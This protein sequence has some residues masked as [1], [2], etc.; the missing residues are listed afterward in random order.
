MA[1]IR[2]LIEAR[3]FNAVK[4]VLS[5]QSKG[6]RQKDEIREQYICDAKREVCADLHEK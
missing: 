6:R 2:A 5:Q 4:I 1:A 3:T